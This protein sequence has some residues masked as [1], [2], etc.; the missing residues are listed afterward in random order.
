MDAQPVTE[1]KR[2]RGRPRLTPQ[3][4][5]ARAAALL[6]KR[7]SG[8]TLRE[9]AEDLNITLR[10]AQKALSGDMVRGILGNASS[11]LT[12]S[13]IP[14]A[15]AVYE[16]ALDDGNVDVAT[17]V[18]EGAGLIG[19]ASQQLNINVSAP[20][21]SLE[22]FRFRLIRQRQLRGDLPVV[23]AEALPAADPIACEAPAADSPDRGVP[24][25]VPE[26]PT[27]VGTQAPA[28]SL[29]IDQLMARIGQGV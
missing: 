19:K 21:D 10:T 13:L 1:F 4:K 28:A 9:A 11:Y 23:E 5:E 8:K 18:L 17:Q 22:A 20:E 7:I 14:K 27:P 16:A 12:G 29:S 25:V 26:T 2:K 6:A 24:P 3:E 15:L